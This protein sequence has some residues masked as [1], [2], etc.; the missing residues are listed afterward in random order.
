MFPLLNITTNQIN[1][2]NKNNILIISY[3]LT[4]PPHPP[5]FPRLKRGRTSQVAMTLRHHC[6]IHWCHQKNRSLEMETT[7]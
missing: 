5:A 7:S 1:R 6:Q 2:H 4:P 3:E